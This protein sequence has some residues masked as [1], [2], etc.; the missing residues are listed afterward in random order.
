LRSST[1]EFIENKAKDYGQQ[2][3]SKLYDNI[4]ELNSQ[5][6]IAYDLKKVMENRIKVGRQR[7]PLYERLWLIGSI[8]T[9][10]GGA[11]GGSVNALLGGLGMVGALEVF[12]IPRV[13]NFIA[14]R[15]SLMTHG[16]FKQFLGEV[17]NYKKTQNLG[18]LQRQMR[19]EAMRY[20]RLGGV[21]GQRGEEARQR[22]PIKKP[23]VQ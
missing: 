16:E 4:R 3:G 10:G 14:S 8:G 17:G 6:H 7:M 1:R 22:I 5:T 13:K 9:A 11:I 20:A 23:T 19:R 2:T 21:A 12:R 18:P 15:I